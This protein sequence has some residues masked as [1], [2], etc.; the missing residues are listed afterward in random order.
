MFGARFM[1]PAP[2]RAL[3]RAQDPRRRPDARRRPRSAAD[4]AARRQ[5]TGQPGS[6]RLGLSSAS[7]R[8]ESAAPASRSGE[9]RL[10]EPVAAGAKATEN[11]AP[12]LCNRDGVAA[13]RGGGRDVVAA[14][15]VQARSW[16][17]S[18]AGWRSTRSGR[19]R[20]PRRRSRTA[21]S[22]SRPA[23]ASGNR[24]LVHCEGASTIHSAERDVDPRDGDSL[25]ER[26]LLGPSQPAVSVTRCPVTTRWP[27]SVSPAL[28]LQA[29]RASTARAPARTRRWRPP[30][31]GAAVD[32]GADL[33]ERAGAEAEAAEPDPDRRVARG[34]GRQV[35]R[36]LA[37][38]GRRPAGTR[39]PPRWTA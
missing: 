13:A 38:D 20:S 21:R 17:R 15:G 33:F 37:P 34:T 2:A 10:T 1:L 12:D 26:L 27:A 7:R 16:S 19:P 4:A 31:R 14:F 35:S 36:G 28:G 5:R 29:G 25:G 18:T 8:T 39:R 11:A 24:R 30:T 32:L 22:R 6:A 23:G 9:G 3:H